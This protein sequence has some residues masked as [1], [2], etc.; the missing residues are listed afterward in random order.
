MNNKLKFITL[1]FNVLRRDPM[2][3]HMENT[4]EDSPWHREKNVLVHTD[5]VVA[6]YI[7]N[8][9]YS[10]VSLLGAFASAFHDV[11]KPAAEEERTNK[12]TNV[13]Y[14]RY[15]G[16]EMISSRMWENWAVLNFQM[17]ETEFGFS[18]RDIYIVGWVIQNHLP[19]SIKKPDKKNRLRRTAAETIGIDMFTMC[20]TADCFGRISDNH[21]DKKNDLQEWCS[22][23]TFGKGYRE[24]VH[25]PAEGSPNC[26]VLIGAPGCGKSTWST[27]NASNFVHYHSLDQIR[28]EQYSSDYAEAFRLSCEDKE[29]TRTSQADFM[30]K[31]KTGESVCVDNTNVSAKRRAFYVDNARRKGYAVTAVL[32]LADLDTLIGRQSSRSDKTVPDD[33]VR[34]LYENLQLPFYGEFDTVEVVMNQ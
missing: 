7:A 23:L 21:D 12:E 20:L 33:A 4:V 26:Y 17:L 10:W 34:R 1:Y 30:E 15:A 8:M 6:N 24:E 18:L 16:H 32:F 14:R 29:F 28:L 19:F 3:L 2:F 5:M 25:I 27:L 13:I 9:N 22:D 31:I 11:G